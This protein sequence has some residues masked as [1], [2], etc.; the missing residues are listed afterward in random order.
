MSKLSQFRT[1]GKKIVCVGRNYREHA[2]ELGN[3]VPSKP[4]LFLKPTS[5]YI[6]EG[7]AIKIPQGCNDLNH[8]VELGVVIGSK[9]I[10]VAPEEALNYV[11][12]Y[13]L[14]LDMTARDWQSEAKK[15]GHPWSLAKGF[16]TSCPVSAFI[17]KEKIPDPNNIDLWLKVNGETKQAGNTKDMIFSVEYLVSY[18]SQYFT[19][20]PG[21][22]LLTGTPSG[23]SKLK[24]GDIIQ[25]GLGNLI[26]MQFKVDK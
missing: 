10:Q 23:V 6:S 3:P 25:A 21:D 1:F 11:G 7:Q 26:S 17:E 2:A 24:P 5:A 22:L 18:A 4:I 14:G 20:E 16:D 12:G 8:E 9:A 15:Q 13:A 19:L